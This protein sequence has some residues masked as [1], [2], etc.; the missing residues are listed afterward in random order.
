MATGIES[1]PLISDG[2]SVEAIPGGPGY[3]PKTA[4][5]PTPH[6]NDELAS[7]VWERVKRARAA[8][9]QLHDE[10]RKYWAFY[11]GDQWAGIDRKGRSQLTVNFTFQLIEAQVPLVIGNK[12]HIYA[13]PRTVDP[14]DG[15]FQQAADEINKYFE[16]LWDVEGIQSIMERLRREASIVG[17]G[18]LKPIERLKWNS[19]YKAWEP[20]G[21]RIEQVSSFNVYP[22]PEAKSIDDCEYVAICSRPSLRALNYHY[23]V[24]MEKARRW[25][26]SR[27]TTDREPDN[28]L[29]PTGLGSADQRV[30]V[31]EVWL[32]GGERVVTLVEKSGEILRDIKNPFAHGQI[33]LCPI[34]NV[35]TNGIF[36]MGDVQQLKPLQEEFNQI[37][38]LIVDCGKLTANPIIVIQNGNYTSQVANLPGAIV[39]VNDI[40]QFRRESGVAMPGYVF[41]ILRDIKEEMERIVGVPDIARGERPGRI[42]AMGA[43]QALQTAAN[44]RMSQKAGQVEEGLARMGRQV[45]SLLRQYHSG[46]TSLS[47]VNPLEGRIETA[48]ISPGTLVYDFDILVQSG[49]TLPK[50]KGDLANMAMELFKITNGAIGIPVLLK[51]LEFPYQREVIQNLQ[52]QAAVGR[53]APPAL[54]P[55]AGPPEGM[56]GAPGPPPQSAPATAGGNGE[57]GPVT[58]EMMMQLEA[59]MQ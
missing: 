38:S 24:P 55:P 37:R 33:P 18:W 16:V 15:G 28:L 48:A 23:G 6:R 12:P 34:Y 26:D 58:P 1:L 43:I 39:R 32:D 45:V 9:V 47:G 53:Q 36:G 2:Q 14:E 5:R 52:A 27:S 20:T 30:T 10:W 29:S 31:W 44:Q 25:V 42:V 17:Q 56:P 19:Q 35:E 3:V 7:A 41:Q 49:S 8:K 22:E 13:S 54:G 21:I 57:P 11:Q 50:N 59:M 40:Q 51:A 4:Q 46:G